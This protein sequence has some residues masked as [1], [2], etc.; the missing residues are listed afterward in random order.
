MIMS[1]IVRFTTREARPGI[2]SRYWR[3]DTRFRDWFP[4]GLTWAVPTGSSGPAMAE[5][6]TAVR[7][8][9]TPPTPSSARGRLRPGEGLSRHHGGSTSNEQMFFAF[10]LDV[11]IVT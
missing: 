8:A 6:G 10:I 5:S 7:A 1:R 11:T 2:P 4:D 9:A 3:C